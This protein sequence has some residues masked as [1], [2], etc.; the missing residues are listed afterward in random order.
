MSII[1]SLDDELSL[2]LTGDAEAVRDPY[3]VY[4]RLRQQGPIY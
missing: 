4:E 1:P 2:I 3:P